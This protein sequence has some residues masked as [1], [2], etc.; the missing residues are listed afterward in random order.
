MRLKN[1]DYE[2][3][4]QIHDALVEDSELY[5]ASKLDLLLERFEQ[6]RDKTRTANRERAAENRKAGYLWNSMNRPKH[7]KYYGGE[8]DGNTG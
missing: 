6:E 7:S 2:L 1:E 8:N 4:R 3:L 5:L